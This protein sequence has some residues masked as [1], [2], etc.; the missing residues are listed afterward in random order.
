MKAIG[1]IELEGM[2]FHAHHGCLESEK[3]VGND[4]VALDVS[5]ARQKYVCP[6][7]LKHRDKVG[8][9]KALSKHVFACLEEAWALPCPSFFRL[10]EVPAVTLPQRDMPA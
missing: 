2:E 6:C 1:T 10:I 5:F 4:F 8:Q 7:I 3:V 9:Y